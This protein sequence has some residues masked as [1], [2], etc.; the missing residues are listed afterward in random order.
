MNIDKN[1]YGKTSP[2]KLSKLIETIKKTFPELYHSNTIENDFIL[3][4]CSTIDK[5]SKNDLVFIENSKYIKYLNNCKAGCIIL[6]PKYLSHLNNKNSYI[7]SKMPRRIF[8][9]ALGLLSPG[10]NLSTSKSSISKNSIIKKGALIGNNVKIGDHVI[11]GENS[12]IGDGVSIGDNTEIGSNCSINFSKIGQNSIIYPGVRIGTTGF[13]FNFDDNGV[14]KFPHR[15]RVIIKDN[16]EIGANSTIDRGSLG[17][18]IINSFVMIDNLVHIAHNVIIGK[19][20]VICGQSGI[21]GSTVIGENVII[22][23]QV[24][25]AGHLKISSGVSLSARSGVTKDINNVGL[26][27]GFPALPIKEFRRQKATLSMITK[28]FKQ[29]K[30]YNE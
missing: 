20:T 22:G 3:K 30:K 24:G 6:D 18:T 4:N 23:A 7:F 17:D 8:A 16:V 14:Y 21:A 9:F 2:L 13:G 28:K 10:K 26:V 11:I 19:G 5:F 12:V 29:K 25:I 1:F 15:G 27:G